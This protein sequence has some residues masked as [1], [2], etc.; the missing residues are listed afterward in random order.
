MPG[1][2]SLERKEKRRRE[3]R[4]AK[5]LEASEE[6]DGQVPR[7]DGE[8]DFHFLPTPELDE[9]TGTEH[10]KGIDM[11]HAAFKAMQDYGI[12][13]CT[14]WQL[15]TNWKITELMK[16]P[17][18]A[19]QRFVS[20]LRRH[21][22]IFHVEAEEHGKHVGSLRVRLQ[23]RAESRLPGAEKLAEEMIA[24]DAVLPERTAAEPAS[25]QQVLQA[26][27]VELV[28]SL[29]K[30][31]GLALLQ[32]LGQEVK[33]VTFKKRFA[34]WNNKVSLLDVVKLFTENFWIDDSDANKITVSLVDYGVEDESMLEEYL[35]G[36]DD[37]NKKGF[38]K[39]YGGKGKGGGK[40]KGGELDVQAGSKGGCKGKIKSR[41]VARPTAAPWLTP[42]GEGTALGG[43]KFGLGKGKAGCGK[44]AGCGKGGWGSGGGGFRWGSEWD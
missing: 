20:I 17:E 30:Q 19:G 1:K 27:R 9:L 43:G 29:H 36:G 44:A 13:G 10:E 15:R 37:D 21:G 18:F 28:H 12:T 35:Q 41:P 6:H 4:E 5:D 40:S 2:G 24:Q 16:E 26:L 7:T 31:D 39:G 25:P 3:Q 33:V 38:R 23:P 34:V 32:D 22:D 8:R 14:L 11:C 42:K